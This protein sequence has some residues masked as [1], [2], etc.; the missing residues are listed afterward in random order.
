M[1]KNRSFLFSI[2][3]ALSGA[4]GG[5]GIKFLRRFFIP[6][7]FTS[8]AY[9]KYQNLWVLLLLSLIYWYSSGYGENSWVR[10]LFKGNNYLTRGFI[11]VGKSMS[12][13]ILPL[14]NNNWLFYIL[15]SIS[16]ILTGA[17]ISWR[18]FGEIKFFKYKLLVVDLI[19]YGVDG[20]VIS[21]LI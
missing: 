6:L 17:L 7:L 18:N 12:I 5:Q 8:L 13:L 4:L 21:I 1:K 19:T 11:S 3:S 9:W 16:I 14:I 20:A 10:K 15:G 2:F